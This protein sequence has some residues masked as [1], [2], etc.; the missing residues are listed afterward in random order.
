MSFPQRI[1]PVTDSVTLAFWRAA[2][3]GALDE[4]MSVLP[5]VR[6]INAR[7][8]HGVTALMRAA[9]F[10]H[11]K[12]VRVLLDQGADADITRNDKFSALA[13]AA[14]FGHTEIVRTLMEHGADSKA[15]TRHGTSPHMWATARTF[16]EVVDQLENP[17][18]PKPAQRLAPAIVEVHDVP[19]NV[20]P[21]VIRTLKDPPEIWDLVHEVPKGFNA[22]S[23]FKSRLNSIQKGLGF[24][25]AI[26]GVL[27]AVVAGGVLVLRRAPGRSQAK[28]ESQPVTVAVDSRVNEARASVPVVPSAEVREDSAIEETTAPLVTRSPSAFPRR[29]PANS[30]HRVKRDVPERVASS[31]GADVQPVAAKSEKM[32]VPVR[33]EPATGTKVS[34]PLS[35]QLISPAKNA[36]PK[37]K[38]IQWP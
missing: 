14:F 2:E 38:V 20:R 4:L 5:R 24:R 31:S 27:I 13:L 11:A 18:P 30:A 8:E 3:E 10:G 19:V 9:Q 12:V 33:S 23:A 28:A 32:N 15:S 34:A 26:V 29:S 1:A 36:A 16:N 6:D 22:S 37:G 17:A 25:V 35:P 21:R 7:N